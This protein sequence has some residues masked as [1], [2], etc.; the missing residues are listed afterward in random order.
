MPTSF[1]DHFPTYLA[2]ARE[3]QN[4]NQSHDYRRQLFVSFLERAF[5][6]P[7][8]DM[9]IE[10]YI[11]LS[12][13]QTVQ[14]M[15]RI[16]KGWIDAVFGSLVFEFKRDVQQERADGL[17]ELRDYLSHLQDGATSVGL[18]TN[19]LAFEVYVLDDTQADGLRKTDS[20]N[21]DTAAP[22]VAYQWLDAYLL[23]QRDRTP[24]ADD[25]VQRF[26]VNSPTF[27]VAARILREA[28]T[29]FGMAEAG[30]LE[31][32]RQQWAFHLARV[33]GSADVSND[34]MFVRHT[35][36]C[37]F[38]K[39]LAYTARF[40]VGPAS[41]RVEGIVDGSAFEVFGINN[42]GEQDFFAWVTT[43]EARAK[44]VALFRH[45]IA[46]FAVYDLSR[47]NEDLLKQL[48]QSLVGP[49]TRHE[50]GEF[51]TPDWLAE[52]TLREINYRPKQ[53]LLDPAC[54][55]GAFLF[56]ALRRLAAQGMTGAELVDF[57]LE[58]VMG[59][60]VHPLAV[61]IAKINYLLA[62]LPHLQQDTRRRLRAIPI[63]LANSLQVP[64]KSYRIAVIEVPFD[65]QRSF[66]IPVDAAHKPNELS[67]VLYAMGQFAAR[68]ASTPEQR[69]YADFGRFALAKLSSSDDSQ[70]AEEERLTWN[71]NVRWLTE[72]IAKGRDSIWVYVLQNT[73]RPLML[74]H[75]Q[76]DVVA[77]NPPW[78]AYR[79]LQDPTYQREI[80]ALIQ[81]Y[82][83]V[84]TSDTKLFT[85][86]ELATLFYEHCRS[87]YLK[88][89]GTIAFVMPR[90]VI[91]GAR[92]HRAF[93]QRGFSR[94]LDL[95]GVSPCST[96]RRVC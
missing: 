91:T 64:T 94:V 29:A 60:D 75:R 5:E 17:R 90:S 37:Q 79:F 15:A 58:N 69:T 71:T 59:M 44:T 87:V 4:R 2:Q 77:G 45:L 80:K 32:K 19:G 23:R 14:G 40:G 96:Q 95:Q 70:Q 1:D 30:A 12:G 83:L 54:G 93:Q 51:Y 18:L 9:D 36:L 6:I 35:Y 85:Q 63:A 22:H 73:S 78:I 38:A 81:H 57:A 88:E 67:E 74:R 13:G 65:S 52:L 31:V 55:S 33:Y 47:I 46:S 27:A 28:L 66:L 72:L 3:A 92:Q 50:L 56:S 48:Y 10:Q 39:L 42:I 7:T 84:R 25:I 89:G 43:P 16:R 34:E 26:G 76:F 8:A 61:T 24:T 82:G 53:S 62:L 49:E 21:L 41:D 86:M 68:A 11:R 20:I